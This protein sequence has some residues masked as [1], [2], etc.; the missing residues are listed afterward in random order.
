MLLQIREERRDIVAVRPLT[1]TELSAATGIKRVVSL[2]IDNVMR[3]YVEFCGYLLTVTS[4]DVG[5]VH[6][7][8]K[9]ICY[10]KNIQRGFNYPHV[11]IS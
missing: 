3:D 2:S 1:L 11:T 8:A 4:N 9:I 10:A 7:L 5:L 6:Q